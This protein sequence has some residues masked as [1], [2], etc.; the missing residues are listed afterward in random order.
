MKLYLVKT[1]KK[2]LDLDGKIFKDK[3]AKSMFIAD[4][5][6]QGWKVEKITGE[7]K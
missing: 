2:Q 5:A 4:L 6:K 3:K 1:I 7:S